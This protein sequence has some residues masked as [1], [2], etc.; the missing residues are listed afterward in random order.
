M[1]IF[2][3]SLV[4]IHWKFQQL[5]EL[6]SSQFLIHSKSTMK[7]NT[8]HDTVKNYDSFFIF[9]VFY[10]LYFHPSSC[11]PDLRVSRPLILPGYPENTTA[12]VGGQ[13]SLVCKVHRPASSKV[14]W[15]KMDASAPGQSQEGPPHIRALTVKGRHVL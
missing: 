15:L 2:R 11:S 9:P 3:S 12:G 6:V 10:L 8:V 5:H 4:I 7:I 13:A 1:V 14:Q